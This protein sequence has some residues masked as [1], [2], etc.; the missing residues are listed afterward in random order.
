[1]LLFLFFKLLFVCFFPLSLFSMVLSENVAP[2]SLLSLARSMIE[3]TNTA[4]AAPIELCEITFRYI[5]ARFFGNS[6][7]F[8]KLARF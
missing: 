8:G 6:P 5:E 2:M 3:K 7:G 4:I 1:M